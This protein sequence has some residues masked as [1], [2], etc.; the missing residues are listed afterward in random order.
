MH[1]L[2]KSR[3]S[4]LLPRRNNGRCG[5]GGSE[6]S[7]LLTAFSTGWQSVVDK[8]PLHSQSGSERYRLRMVPGLVGICFLCW[9]NFAYHL[10]NLFVAWPTTEGRVGSASLDGSHLTVTY[11]FELSGESFG[12]AATIKSGDEGYSEGQRII[13]AYDPLNPQQ[14]KLRSQIPAGL[15]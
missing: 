6:T 11:N 5:P 14:S 15:A 4:R 9:P 10:T 3:D 13:I 1:L 2:V 7:T 12:G 8:S